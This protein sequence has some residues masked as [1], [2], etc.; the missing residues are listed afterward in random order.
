M[1]THPRDLSEIFQEFKGDFSRNPLPDPN[2][3][4]EKRDEYK[5][6]VERYCELLAPFDAKQIRQMFIKYIQAG[7]IYFPKVGDL[8]KHKPKEEVR[9]GPYIPTYEETQEFIAR[10]RA[11]AEEYRRRL[12]DP[13]EREKIERAKEGL[14][15]EME[16]IQR[17]RGH[18]KESRKVRFDF[19]DM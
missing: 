12:E 13:K 19:D 2:E 10:Q 16:K 9:D 7:G 17:E 5:R 6:M 4:D 1:K 14:R 3:S 11:E 8:A 15:Q 18:A